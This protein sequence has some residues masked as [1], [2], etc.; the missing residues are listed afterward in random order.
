MKHHTRKPHFGTEA[1]MQ[2]SPESS[3]ANEEEFESED[4]PPISVEVKDSDSIQTESKQ[5]KL[6]EQSE[7]QLQEDEPTKG[8][9]NEDALKGEF[10]VGES[11]RS[12]RKHHTR[13]PHFGTEALMQGGPESVNDEVEDLGSFEPNTKDEQIKIG[14]TGL[15][16]KMEMESL[17]SAEKE[18]EEEEEIEIVDNLPLVTFGRESSPAQREPEVYPQ[19]GPTASNSGCVE[20]VTD[21][22][23]GSASSKETEEDFGNVENVPSVVLERKIT[24]EKRL[25]EIYPPR[26][27]PSEESKKKD[28]ESPKPN[29]EAAEE[30]QKEKSG[31]DKKKE[32]QKEEPPKK[33]GIPQLRVAT[34]AA[35]S[36]NDKKKKKKEFG[37][38]VWGSKK[39]KSK[40]SPKSKEKKKNEKDVSSSPSKKRQ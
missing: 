2:G 25:P 23:E 13:E 30:N 18:T 16:Q 35:K 28:E 34:G 27:R 3:L 33:S 40:K 36:E 11:K 32:P 21:G 12:V 31:D 14:E 38:S 1:L 17:L 8:Q 15:L 6:K 10:G 22:E 24:P 7:A 29:D 39:D 26:K 9:L 4:E 37:F 19:K 5:E 20:D